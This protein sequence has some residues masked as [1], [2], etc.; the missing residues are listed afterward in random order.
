[1]VAVA[2]A[3]LIVMAPLGCHRQQ[4]K[5]KIETCLACN[6]FTTILLYY[7][8]ILRNE[9]GK[10]AMNLQILKHYPFNVRYIPFM[11]AN[12]VIISV[13]CRSLAI[14]KVLIGEFNTFACY[15][16]CPFCLLYRFLCIL[17]ICV[18]A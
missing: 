3:V 13:Y 16:Y 7:T 1:M 10:N 2:I 18:S 17:C 4:V 6:S 14:A 15:P 8:R 11:I 12:N 5:N 9:Y